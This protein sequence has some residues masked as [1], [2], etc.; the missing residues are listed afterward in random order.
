MISGSAAGQKG[1]QVANAWLS[2][3]AIESSASVQPE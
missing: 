1:P 2:G 3:V